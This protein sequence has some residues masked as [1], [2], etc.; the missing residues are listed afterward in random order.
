MRGR[1]GVARDDVGVQVHG[2]QGQQA[3]LSRI[4][5]LLGGQQGHLLVGDVGL[6]L[7]QFGRRHAAGVDQRLV[8]LQLPLRPFQRLAGDHQLFLGLHQG[9]VGHDDRR[10]RV[11]DRRLQGQA[12]DAVLQH[13]LGDRRA[14]DR[15]ARA[16]QQGLADAQ[17]RRVGSLAQ[18]RPAQVRSRPDELE[19]GSGRDQPRA[20]E[21]VIWVLEP[22]TPSCR[23]ASVRASINAV[24]AKRRSGHEQVVL[25]GDARQIGRADG[26]IVPQADQH[27]VGQAER[28]LGTDRRRPGGER[29]GDDRP[30][31][32]R[33]PG[34]NRRR[35]GQDQQDHPARPSPDRLGPLASSGRHDET[36]PGLAG[37]PSGVKHQPT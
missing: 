32:P 7:D 17:Q 29:R 25:F 5:L 10:H 14:I 3:Q 4:A 28:Q 8:G 1:Q 34:R 18:A 15:Q 12:V 26:A 23:V 16:A 24:G 37:I 6:G 36:R 33:R 22:R 11:G 35:Q 27:R 19:L 2:Q 20:A 9:A 21:G 13:R 31:R 30:L